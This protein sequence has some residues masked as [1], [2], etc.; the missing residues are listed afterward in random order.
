MLLQSLV[1]KWVIEK[2]RTIVDA[3][4]PW[5]TAR[6][7]PA[8]ST[9]I[10]TPWHSGCRKAMS[11]CVFTLKQHYF[12]DKAPFDTH[13]PLVSVDVH[14]GIAALGSDRCPLG[15]LC[16]HVDVA[17][18]SYVLSIAPSWLNACTS[19]GKGCS[20][21]YTTPPNSSLSRLKGGVECGLAD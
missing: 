20:I 19:Y 9:L 16:T 4:A 7:P 11:S 10:F 15:Q 12:C 5:I 13:A 21:M 8:F 17:I 18:V 1:T 14:A 2:L 6:R 3:I